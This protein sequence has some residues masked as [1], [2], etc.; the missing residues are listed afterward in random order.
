MNFPIERTPE[1]WEQRYPVR[2][3]PTGAT[4]TRFGPS[5][6]GFMHIGG[7]YAA[8]ISRRL[9][10]Q[11]GG[12]FMLRIE[13]TDRR[14]E[15]EGATELIVRSLA[16]YGVIP[17]EGEIAPDKEIGDYGPYRQSR[18]AEIYKSF[19]HQ[20][21]TEGK[22]YPCFATPEELEELAR[23]QEIAKVKPGY[24][25]PYAIWRN[26][27]EDEVRQALDEGRPFVVR[28]RSPVETELKFAFAD[29]IRGTLE[30]PPNDQ[31]IVLLKSDGMPTY[32]FAHVV[33]DHL[34]RT[35]DVIR[36]DEW[37]ASVPVHVQLFAAFGWELPRY[38]HISPIQ[39][40][41]GSSR[42]KLSKRKDPEA[43][44][45]YY[46]EQGYPT[47]AILDYLLHL[48]DS[49]FEDW[50]T[51]HPTANAAEFSVD[52]SH[53]SRSGAL[54]DL[55]KLSSISKD[56]VSTFAGGKLYDL[57]LA[58]AQRHDL[59]LAVEMSRDPHYT[60]QVLNIERT[61]DRVRKD[62]G[63]WS[64]LRHAISFFYDALFQVSE[65]EL[66]ALLG[67]VALPEARAA[68]AEF[69][70]AYD[71]LD[72][73]DGWL[74][75]L[76]AAAANHGFAGS[77]KLF[78]QNPTTYKGHIGDVAKVI[79]VLLTGRNQSPDLWEVMAVMGRERV[80]RRLIATQ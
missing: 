66:S 32:H 22:A 42:R 41:E 53:F 50:R 75:K 10:T 15:V 28:F 58:W 65:E 63:K 24:Y 12:V 9:A 20:L 45:D 11:T 55:D 21:L 48:A 44:I 59:V 79:R 19:A 47:E 13:D 27:T 73:K 17:D 14:R 51:Q 71:P 16:H 70:A 26:R 69:L 4:V 72:D 39:K 33:D 61:G 37:L 74:N 64:E 25:G 34:M 60:Q 80:E 40:M 6:T 8:L 67:D 1:E 38:A 36:G 2:P 77:M 30:L 35:T 3:L 18:R 57:G 5:P 78:K 56:V 31:D 49:T 54:F 43:N 46:D 23:N 29:R 52:F 76:R 7:L 68:M 62:I